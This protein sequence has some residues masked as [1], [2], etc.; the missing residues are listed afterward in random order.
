[1]TRT[2]QKILPRHLKPRLVQLA[3]SQNTEAE[4]SLNEVLSLT[5]R[6]T[7]HASHSIIVATWIRNM[8]W[9][10]MPESESLFKDRWILKSERR[11]QYLLCSVLQPGIFTGWR[12]AANAVPLMKKPVYVCRKGRRVS[13]EYAPPL[14]TSGRLFIRWNDPRA[15]A[16]LEKH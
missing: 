8:R 5:R 3:L 16:E 2:R 12:E 14:L 13:A 11:S 10:R 7:R 15:K 6:I 1:M 9:T 4:A